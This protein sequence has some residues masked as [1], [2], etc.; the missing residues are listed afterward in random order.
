MKLRDMNQYRRGFTLVEL[1]VV[2]AIIGVLVALLLPA[3]QAAREAARRMQCSNNQKQLAL[4]MHNYHDTYGKLP[5]AMSQGFGFTYHAHVYPFME[6]TPLY[7]IIQ[8]QES[9]SGHDNTPN[10]SFSV[11]AK[12]VVKTL[13]C[14]SEKIGYTWAPPIN[15]LSNRAVGSYVGCVGSDV[16]KDVTQAQG[17]IDVRSGNGMLL[18]YHMASDVNKNGPFRFAEI[19]D[20][21]SN[22]FMGGESPF[23]VTGVCTICD[24][25]YGY[26]YDGDAA[27]AASGNND[28]S[29]VVCS[30]YYR[31]NQSMKRG[32]ISGDER[33]LSFGSYHPGG[34][35]MQMGDGSIRFVAENIDLPTWQAAGS[36]NGGETLQVP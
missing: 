10:S 9:G 33:E 36:R 13:K 35:V 14:P 31:M 26:S 3:V 18:V 30:T 6:Q 25:M 27:N 8:F 34:C 29:E 11:L 1:L 12:T 21:L 2:I 24:R 5:W 15:G 28:F 4:A 23:S 7:N 19:S 17:T 32:S 16:T 22:T 20:G